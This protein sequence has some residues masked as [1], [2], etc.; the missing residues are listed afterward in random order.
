MTLKTQKEIEK[1]NK[2][3]NKEHL[4]IEQFWLKVGIW[5]IIILFVA[6]VFVPLVEL[7]DYINPM[8]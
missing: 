6:L 4:G 7:G 3:F 2:F 1:E 5:G 8:P